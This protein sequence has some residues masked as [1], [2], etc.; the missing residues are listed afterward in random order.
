MVDQVTKDEMA[1]A[2]AKMRAAIASLL[3]DTVRLNAEASEQMR[4]ETAKLN[5]EARRVSVSTFLVPFLTAAGLIG[6]TAAVV[7]L[8]L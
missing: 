6:A 4:A 1:L 3:A 8:L 7:K 2:D 5:A